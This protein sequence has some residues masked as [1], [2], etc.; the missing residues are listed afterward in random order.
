MVVLEGPEPG[1]EPDTMVWRDS[2]MRHELNEIME[3]RLAELQPRRRLM[4][5]ADKIYNNDNIVRAAWSLRHGPVAQ[6]M[7]DENAIMAG[8]RVA[9]EWTFGTI[10]MLNKY[11]DFCK[12]QKLMESPLAEHYIVAVLLSN[13]HNCIYGDEHIGFFNCEPVTLADYL[14]Q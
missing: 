4:L 12:G 1:F 7:T 9:I 11:V 5:Y 3:E 13:C 14:S 2:Q 6:W 8:I 10:I